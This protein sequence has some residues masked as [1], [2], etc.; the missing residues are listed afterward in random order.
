[1]TVVTATDFGVDQ[2]YKIG[3]FYPTITLTIPRVNS[4]TFVALAPEPELLFNAC[5]QEVSGGE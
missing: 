1:M 2:M 3:A 5:A 4:V